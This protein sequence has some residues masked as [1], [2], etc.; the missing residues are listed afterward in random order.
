[1]KNLSK[2]PLS[3]SQIDF[4]NGDLNKTTEQLQFMA[5]CI[6]NAMNGTISLTNA[7]KEEAEELEYSKML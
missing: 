7:Q 3:L 2:S 4:S 5:D 1:M 6:D